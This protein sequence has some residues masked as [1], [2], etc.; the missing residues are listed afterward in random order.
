MLFKGPERGILLFQE[1][2]GVGGVSEGAGSSAE[3]AGRTTARRCR[4]KSSVAV[5]AGRFRSADTAI[6]SFI[7]GRA[8][9]PPSLTAVSFRWA[10]PLPPLCFFLGRLESGRADESEVPERSHTLVDG[11]TQYKKKEHCRQ[12]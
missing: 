5:S 9:P 12:L 3:S 2:H 6:G 8:K 7:F 11:T 4:P 10:Q 1:A